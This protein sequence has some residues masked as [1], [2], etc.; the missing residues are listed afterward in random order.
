[1]HNVFWDKKR[2]TRLK[3]TTGVLQRSV[4]GPFLFLIYLNDLLDYPKNNNH[5]AMFAD[6]TSLLKTGKPKECQIQEDIDNL[7]VWFT[8]NRLTVNAFKCEVM[9]FGQEGQQ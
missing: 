3:V 4:L 6:D 9:K 7:A 2:S 8:S 5:F 1:M